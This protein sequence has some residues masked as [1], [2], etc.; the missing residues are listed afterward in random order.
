MGD[1]RL[2]TRL[3]ANRKRGRNLVVSVNI[4]YRTAGYRES[5]SILADTSAMFAAVEQRFVV[6]R[7]MHYVS[8]RRPPGILALTPGDVGRKRSTTGGG[9]SWG[10]CKRSVTNSQQ[11]AMQTYGLLRNTFFG[12]FLAMVRINREFL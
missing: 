9:G 6:K 5:K 7:T 1:A 11:D 12:Q 8:I 3:A 2:T 4:R 10:P